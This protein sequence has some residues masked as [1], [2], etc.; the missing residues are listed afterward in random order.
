MMGQR[1]SDGHALLQGLESTRFGSMALNGNPFGWFAQ[2]LVPE[3]KVFEVHIE[4]GHKVGG[5]SCS[6][7][8][9]PYSN[10]NLTEQPK[11]PPTPS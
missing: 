4:Q 11:P 3:R 2:G 5:P 7:T 6:G 9:R 10:P 8:V 1:T